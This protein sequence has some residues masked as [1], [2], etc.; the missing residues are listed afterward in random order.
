MAAASEDQSRANRPRGLLRV[1]RRYYAA[2]RGQPRVRR[3]TD[4]LGLVASLIALAGVVAAQPPSS[5]ERS[6][7][8][9]LLAFPSWLTPIWAIM[10][11]AL[12]AWAVF[13]VVFPLFSHRPRITLEALLAVALSMGLGLLAARLA[14]GN[15]PGAHETSGLSTDLRF[16]GVRLAMAAAAIFVA[17]AHLTKPLGATGRRMLAL[18]AVGLMLDGKTSVGG[19]AAALLI[20]LAAG[21]AVRLALG[22]SAGQP[23]VADV[24]AALDDL[25]VDARGLEPARHQS[26]GVFVVHGQAVDGGPL[27]V[28]VYGRDAYDNQTLEKLWRTLWYRDAGMTV[29]GLNR[30]RGAEREALLTLLARN[31]GAPT[32]AVVTAGATARDDSLVVLRVGGTSLA[33]L[34]P[35]QIDDALLASSWEA[36]K[37]LDAANVAHGHIS[38]ASLRSENG[39][40]SVVDLGG[41]TVAPDLDDRLTDRAQLLATTAAVAG[42]ERSVAAALAAIGRDDLSALLPYLQPAAFGQPLRKALKTSGIDVDDLRKLAATAAGQPEPELAQLRRVTWESLLQVA[43]L[44]FAGG[45]VLSFVGGVDAHEFADA[46]RDASWTW[47]VAG[48]VVAQ[49]PRISQAVATRASAPA[50]VPFGP[51]YVLQLATS[52]VNLAV[53]TSFGSVAVGV[54]FFQRQGMSAA[55]A[56]TSGTINTFANN[57]VQAGLLGL[58]LLFSGATLNLDIGTPSASGA[59]HILL[60]LLAIAAVAAIGCAVLGYLGRARA[61]VREHFGRWWPEVRRTLGS[62]RSSHKLPQLILGNVATEVLFATALGLFARA[63]GFPLSIADLLVINMSTSLFSSLIPVPGG[64]GVVE[65]GLVVGLSADGMTQS[66]AF[67][68][69]LLYRICTFY[70]PPIWGWFALR[71]LR[72]NQYL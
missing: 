43:L 13:V 19:T 23:T 37:D 22:T 68:A 10:I 29:S 27:T 21:A 31:A 12:V 61:A 20:G 11:G 59:T 5:L 67:A 17:N 46:V 65:G 47:I 8:R 18:G 6:F 69:V 1:G 41:G 71:W 4:L 56:L 55:S 24:A 7:L 51:V 60:L 33:S 2:P 42:S 35:E 64:I 44:A 36:V 34:P 58:L 50:A 53:P 26:A 72:H 49:L 16:P 14:T 52:Y 62:L 25:G 54:R 28:K 48:A 3:A 45:S 57:V 63:L 66:S 15:W 32:A 70:L 40:V 9:F 38:P 30:A 39:S